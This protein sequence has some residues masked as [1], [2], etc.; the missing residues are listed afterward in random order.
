MKRS[1]AD[2]RIYLITDR[3]IFEGD[4]DALLRGVEGALEGGVKAVQLREKDLETRTLLAL[5]YRMR[6]L[7][8]RYG[9]RLFIND[10]ADIAVAVS[11]D[12]VHLG[13]TGIPVEAARKVCGE[14]MLIGRSTHSLEEARQAQEA[15]AD[16]ITFGPVFETPSK[17]PYG[18]PVGVK[19]LR[20]TTE[21]ISIPVFAIG[22]ISR[23]K[24]QEVTEAGASGIALISGIL[25]AGDIKSG[26]ENFV[27]TIP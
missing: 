23:E 3:K 16:F 25:A 7:T 24:V 5:A 2:F 26:T 15:G 13:H 19:L 22:G 4:T 21:R 8:A 11:A 1:R 12:G 18:E 20:D 10:R 27:R 9:A 6:E 17:R 14:K